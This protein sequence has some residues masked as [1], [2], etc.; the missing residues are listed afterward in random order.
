MVSG[1]LV[2]DLQAD[3]YVLFV[4]NSPCSPG[5]EIYQIDDVSLVDGARLLQGRCILSAI[6]PRD[7]LLK[8]DNRFNVSLITLTRTSPSSVLYF[9][10]EMHTLILRSICCR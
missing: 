10:Q 1:T 6:P 4:H 3:R 8:F 2:K 9:L 7:T 5:P